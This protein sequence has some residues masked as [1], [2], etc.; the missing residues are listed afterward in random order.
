[1]AIVIIAIDPA[2]DEEISEIIR[3]VTEARE[4]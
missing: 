1:M 3:P 4:K 2:R